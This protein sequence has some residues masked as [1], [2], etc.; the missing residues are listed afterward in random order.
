MKHLNLVGMV[1]FLSSSVLPV[2][3][4]AQ[5][6]DAKPNEPQIQSQSAP[7]QPERT[8]EQS[9]QARKQDDRKAEDTRINRDWSTRPRYDER[10]DMDRL[11][12]MDQDR[13]SRTVGQ[14][15]R[16]DE[17]ERDRGYRYGW[18]DRDEDRLYDNRPR[19]RVK[20]CIEY[21]NGD[22]F[23]RYRD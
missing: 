9:D 14:S 17:D 22:E 1:L 11:R 7:V 5:Q 20:T 12:R 13:D 8:P 19:H 2:A 4:F 10:A 18:R 6:P 23:C 16:R 3:V 15:Y 21:D